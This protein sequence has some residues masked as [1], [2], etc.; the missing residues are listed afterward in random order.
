VVQAPRRQQQVQQ[1]IADLVD[2]VAGVR[3][4]RRDREVFKR[5]KR[6]PKQQKYGSKE[7]A[8]DQRAGIDRQGDCAIFKR[9]ETELC[10]GCLVRDY[11]DRNLAGLD[12]GTVSAPVRMAPRIFCASAPSCEAN[13]SMVLVSCLSAAA[14]SRM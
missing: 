7:Q 5:A 14:T 2:Q 9:Q 12:V 1:R 13:C 6:D 11:A 3:H 8:A 4:L 10:Q